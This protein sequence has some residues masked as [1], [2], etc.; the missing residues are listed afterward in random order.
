M[1]NTPELRAD[2]IDPELHAAM[3]AV[4]EIAF[5]KDLNAIVVIGDDDDRFQKRANVSPEFKEKALTII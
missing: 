3:E 2:W 5:R 1:K 4:I